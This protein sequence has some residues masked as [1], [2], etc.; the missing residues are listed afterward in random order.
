MKTFLETCRDIEQNYIDA[1]K[2][3]LIFGFGTLLSLF[4]FRQAEIRQ[5]RVIQY[6]TMKEMEVLQQAEKTCASKVDYIKRTEINGKW[7]FE[8]GCGVN[9]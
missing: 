4:I 2:L 8:V 7:Q 6:R 1:V 9:N 5:K 3:G